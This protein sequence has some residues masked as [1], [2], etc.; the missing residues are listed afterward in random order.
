MVNSFTNSPHKAIKNLHLLIEK[1]GQTID[2]NSAI[3]FYGLL[4]NNYDDIQDYTNSIKVCDIL[5]RDIEGLPDTM[6]ND[7]IARKIW[8]EKMS[9]LPQMQIKKNDHNVI[10]NYNNFS[11][12]KSSIVFDIIYNSTA[13][14]TILDTGSTVTVINKKAAS[15]I[16]V[17]YFPD[18]NIKLNRNRINGEYALV[19]SL[20]IGNYIFYN[21]PVIVLPN[22]GKSNNRKANK[23]IKDINKIDCILG[24]SVLKHIDEI[25]INTRKKYLLFPKEIS[26]IHTGNTMQLVDNQLSIKIFLNNEKF[27]GVWDTGSNIDLII[28]NS[29]YVKYQNLTPDTS[30]VALPIITYNGVSS[31]SSWKCSNV[32]VKIGNAKIMF[33]KAYLLKDS[34]FPYDGKIGDFIFDNEHIIINF[35]KMLLSCQ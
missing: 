16:G 28:N 34:P 30:F 23:Y 2:A 29:Y 11:D 9:N 6:K 7:I 10:I 27:I 3:Q 21:L 33:P 32:S 25:R 5:L 1:Y 35:R 22:I 26:E 17:K 14:K 12:L 4:M 15:K 8:C 19:D 18:N 24:M 13:L 31:F 20:Q